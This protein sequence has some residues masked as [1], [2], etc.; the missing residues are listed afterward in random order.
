MMSQGQIFAAIALFDELI[1]A[2]ML[3]LITLQILVFIRTKSLPSHRLWIRLG[4][5]V[6][7]WLAIV[8]FV[9][10]PQWQGRDN[11]NRVLLVSKNTPSVAAQAA[12]D[13]L[14]ITEVFSIEDFTQRMTQNPHFVQNIGE[15]F[16]LGQDFNPLLLAQLSQ[17]KIQW[18]PSF[19]TNE[20]QDIAW[21]AILRKGEFQEVSGKIELEESIVLKL[22]Y[23][24]QVLDSVLLPKGLQTFHLR[25]PVFTI[26]RTAMTLELGDELLQ[27]V[28][29]YARKPVLSSV[30]FILEN[31]DFESKTLAEWLGKN[32]Y[33][34]EMRTTIAQNT[35]SKVRINLPNSQQMSNPS[36]VVTDPAN[37]NHPTLKKTLT[38][39][40]SVL[41]YNI[42]NVDQA[43][44][45]SNSA[46][47]TKWRIKKTSNQESISVGSNLTA[48]P[49]QIE[50]SNNQKEVDG[51]PVAVQKV[52][53][54]VGISLLNE[55][56]PL[57]LSDDT[58][59][60]HKI[61]SSILYLLNPPAENNID[62]E[63]PLWKDAKSAITLN[64]FPQSTQAL[65]LA[66]DSTP[67]RPS[68][69]NESTTTSSYRFRKAGWQPFQDSLEV[70]VEDESTALAKA[71]QIQEI[72]QVYEAKNTIQQNTSTQAFAQ[73][74]PDWAWGV[75]VLVC[76]TTV[77]VEP[78]LKF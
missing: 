61:W 54:R 66:N 53:G 72:T 36:I 6:L 69:L 62:I 18:L 78:K 3:G 71:R 75:L 46:L 27:K 21:K 1:Y 24:N 56:F 51:Y 59:T 2:A 76:F 39:G 19:K 34:V 23:A 58:L 64:N 11:T 60:Y 33:T 20:L 35:Q 9:I 16:L 29:F 31:P 74:L 77:W 73:S 4:L 42:T 41:L 44:K 14:T 48:L 15:V 57:K 25:F 38:E 32:G 22:K 43:I 47:G 7:L 28:T 26:D 50:R 68:A 30:Y 55:T 13:S 8:L 45:N 10:Q 40:K 63:A 37:A 49:Y 67:L 12:K 5:N 65:I 52:G 70:Y 17:K